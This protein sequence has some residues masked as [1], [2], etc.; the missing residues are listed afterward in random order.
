M[1]QS[2]QPPDYTFVGPVTEC[3]GCTC[4]W[5]NVPMVLD[6]ETHL[7][8]LIGLDVLC[9]SCGAQCKLATPLDDIPREFSGL[10]YGDVPD[11]D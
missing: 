4:E 3:P 9:M 8:G 5:F 7:P 10:E 11:F 1:T 6:P 2:E